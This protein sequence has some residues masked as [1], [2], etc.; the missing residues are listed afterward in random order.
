MWKEVM[1]SFSLCYAWQYKNAESSGFHGYKVFERDEILAQ[2]DAI[3]L[4]FS[5]SEQG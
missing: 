2:I 3:F 5:V 4:A 1:V